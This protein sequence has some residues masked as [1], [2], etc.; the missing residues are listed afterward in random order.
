MDGTSRC[1]SCMLNGNQ[2]LLTCD[3]QLAAATT[4]VPPG[5]HVHLGIILNTVSRNLL[6]GVADNKHFS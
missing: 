6:W 4:T 3:T 1:V 2:R 5:A